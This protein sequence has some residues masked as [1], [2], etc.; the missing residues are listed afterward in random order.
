M[1][2]IMLNGF[3]IINTSDYFKTK[4]K[5]KLDQKDLETIFIFAK[6]GLGSEDICKALKFD[7]EFFSSCK[8]I[9]ST[10]EQ[11]NAIFRCNLLG[12]QVDKALK[13]ND[14]KMQIWLGK[15]YLGQKDNHDDEFKSES[16]IISNDIPEII[17]VDIK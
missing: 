13:G 1:N 8:E 12:A 3:D 10:I 5:K 17:D 6:N 4:L 16:F 15:Q 14:T 7:N 11:G 9:Q 2:E